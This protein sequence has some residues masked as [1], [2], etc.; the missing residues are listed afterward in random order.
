GEPVDRVVR[1]AYRL[2]LRLLAGGAG[3]LFNREHRAERLLLYA[4]HR[5]VAP[6]EDRGE[7]EVSIRELSTLGAGSA[8]EQLR[9]LGDAVGHVLLHLRHMVGGDER[10]GVGVVVE[11]A[12]DLDESGGLDVPLDELAADR[13]L[14]EGAGA[15]GA[16]LAG[17]DAARRAARL[18]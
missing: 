10:A 16:H 6:A 11:R 1:D 5:R 12:A 8:D 14:E 17:G 15:A 13:V 2:V 7:V 18:E 9:A 3:E 4:R